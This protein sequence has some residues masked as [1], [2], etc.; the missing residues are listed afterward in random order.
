MWW[1]VGV[2]ARQQTRVD[3][4]MSGLK[5]TRL[6]AKPVRRAG[7]RHL[8]AP[9]WTFFVSLSCGAHTCLASVPRPLRKAPRSIIGRPKGAAAEGGVR[10]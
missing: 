3:G 1:G 10:E 7:G 4:R 6:P 2:E 8:L 5:G 9:P